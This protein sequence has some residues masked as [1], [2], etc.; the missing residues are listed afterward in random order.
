MKSTDNDGVIKC[1]LYFKRDEK[2]IGNGK[3]LR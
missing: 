2:V 1:F 3:W